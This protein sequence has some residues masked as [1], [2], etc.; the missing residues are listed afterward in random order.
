[1]APLASAGL[2]GPARPAEP[3]EPPEVAELAEL[4][5]RPISPI[6]GGG[7]AEPIESMQSIERD[8]ILKALAYCSGNV[9]RAAATLG[10]GR[11]TLHRKLKKYNIVPN[12]HSVPRGAS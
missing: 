3:S 10:I 2:V 7:R 11:S 5:E 8:A 1:V 12:R 4:A 6:P 9:S